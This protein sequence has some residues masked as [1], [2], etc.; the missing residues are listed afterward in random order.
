MEPGLDRKFK[1]KK[2]GRSSHLLQKW[3]HGDTSSLPPAAVNSFLEIHTR[4]LLSSVWAAFEAENPEYENRSE[5]SSFGK[6]SKNIDSVC[7]C[8]CV[9]VRERE[10]E[11]ENDEETAKGK[12]EECETGK[13]C[14]EHRFIQCRYCS[15]YCQLRVHTVPVCVCV[16][17]RVCAC[18]CRSDPHSAHQLFPSTGIKTKKSGKEAPKC[19][20]AHVLLPPR[21]VPFPN[22]PPSLAPS[23]AFLTF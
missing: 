8:V 1:R 14:T 15:R 12:W 17:L 21:H 22:L 18:S 3:L 6:C 20:L 5:I 23:S 11:M 2:P 4:T 19:K 10:G 9:C 13:L 7:V 16:Y